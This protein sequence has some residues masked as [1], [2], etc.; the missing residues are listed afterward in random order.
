MYEG[1]RLDESYD[2]DYCSPNLHRELIVATSEKM[3]EPLRYHRP[4]QVAILS[5]LADEDARLNA[6]RK[7]LSITTAG[8]LQRRYFKIHL[9]EDGSTLSKLII[10][11]CLS[12]INSEFP[13]LAKERRAYYAYLDYTL[14]D[15]A[16]LIDCA[17][18]ATCLRKIESSWERP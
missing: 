10:E 8:G 3:Y 4:L 18:T 13:I 15:D 5:L 12:I 2:A 14:V 6:I 9:I 7:V 11:E 16:R 17:L 1:T